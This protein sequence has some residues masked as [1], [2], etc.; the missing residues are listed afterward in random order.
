V[1]ISKIFEE[2]FGGTKFNNC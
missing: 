2:I 1:N